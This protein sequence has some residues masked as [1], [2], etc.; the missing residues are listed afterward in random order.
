MEFID[1]VRY[2]GMI[3]HI[4]IDGSKTL[5]TSTIQ[6]RVCFDHTYLIYQIYTNKLHMKYKKTLKVLI[7]KLMQ[8]DLRMSNIRVKNI[9][10]I[11]VLYLIH[12]HESSNK[13]T[14]TKFY[15]IF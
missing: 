13:V 6:S 4:N 7:G 5:G 12:V 11:L 3:C 10:G 2:A 9:L 14:F 8:I 15:R 1:Y